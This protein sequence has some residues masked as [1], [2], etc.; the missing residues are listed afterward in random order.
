MNAAFFWPMFVLVGVIA[1]VWLR[2]YQVRIAEMR[3][4]GI[5]PQSISTSATKTKLTDTRV[6]DNF[7]NLFEVPVLFFAACGVNLVIVGDAALALGLA[8][9]YVLLRA[10]HSLIQVT[11]NRVMHRF[12]V[13][14][15]STVVV[16]A[17][18]VAT[19][20]RVMQVA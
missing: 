4:K 2:M 20:W 19:A 5:H 8:W 1:I 12:S 6:A 14:V 16:F 9:L 17:L 11:Y 3:E 13:Y 10:G 7:N 18:W 15:A